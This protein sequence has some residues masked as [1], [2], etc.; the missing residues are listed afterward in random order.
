MTFLLRFDDGDENWVQYGPD[1]V[2]N[3]CWQRYCRN[4]PELKILLRS[5]VDAGIWISGLRRLAIPISFC[6]GKFYLDL[7]YIDF[8]WYDTQCELPNSDTETYVVEAQFTGYSNVQNSRGNVYIPVFDLKL[9]KLDYYWFQTNAYRTEI[10]PHLVTLVDSGFVLANPQLVGHNSDRL[11]QLRREYS[12]PLA[13][14]AAHRRGKFRASDTDPNPSL[15]TIPRS[16][17][18]HLL[19]DNDDPISKE[20]KTNSRTPLVSRDIVPSKV[21]SRIPSRQ[22]LRIRSRSN[23]PI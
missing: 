2:T 15:V 18:R 14:T 1:L 11:R 20:P 13:G 17:P 9:T 16:E 4:A 5:A 6:P 3:I 19:D 7:R 12:A 23:S 22:S 21:P 10:D 8:T